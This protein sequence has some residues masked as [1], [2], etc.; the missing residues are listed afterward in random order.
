MLSK[1]DYLKMYLEARC[2][3][4]APHRVQSVHGRLIFSRERTQQHGLD[5]IS[6]AQVAAPVIKVMVIP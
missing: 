1:T 2:M 3:P 5:V 4:L 6:A